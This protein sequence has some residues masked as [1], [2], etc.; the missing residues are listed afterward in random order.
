MSGRG[1]RTVNQ[2]L[3]TQP[4]LGP[5]PADQIVPWSVVALLGYFI[6]QIF[7]WD[8]VWMGIFITWGCSTWWVLTGSKGWK[9]LS[10]FVGVPRVVRGYKRLILLSRKEI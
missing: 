1:F 2:I 10:K 8:W 4:R 9:F 5:F 6:K 3:G 7:H